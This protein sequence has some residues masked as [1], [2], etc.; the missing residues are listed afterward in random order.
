MVDELDA[1][2][3]AL[4]TAY[5]RDAGPSSAATERLLASVRRSAAGAPEAQVLPLRRRVSPQ[6]VG[7]AIVGLVA[8]AVALAIQVAPRRL[9]AEAEAARSAAALQGAEATTSESVTTRR[10]GGRAP[11]RGAGAEDSD[12]GAAD[13][14]AGGAGVAGNVGSAGTADA[15]S[16]GVARNV[17]SAVAAGD[18]GNAGNADSAGTVVNVGSIGNVGRAGAAVNVGSVGRSASDGAAGRASAE[19]SP[20]PANP[21]SG[22]ASGR[23]RDESVATGDPHGGAAEVAGA[24]GL[25]QELALVRAVNDALAGGSPEQAL[26]RLADYQ[27][28]FPGGALREEAAALRAVALCAAGREDGA[29]AATAFLGAHPGSLSAERV[30]RAC[31]VR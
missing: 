24:D 1:R 30:R 12:G 7:V 22:A 14:N 4:L 27:Q 25:A 6:W 10:A 13:A 11:L 17:G 5:R 2:A 21:K 18:V 15:E 19:G 9:D 29:A 20:A 8:A 31:G 28:R 3:R 23:R 26:T 16:A